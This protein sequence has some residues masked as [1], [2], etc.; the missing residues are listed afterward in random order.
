[1]ISKTLY[2]P[3]QVLLNDYFK[4][5]FMKIYM[6]EFTWTWLFAHQK[7]KVCYKAIDH[8]KYNKKKNH[9]INL[10]F[11]YYIFSVRCF[12]VHYY[13]KQIEGIVLSQFSLITS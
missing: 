5:F 12:S 7:L 6:I 3:G 2:I 9:K 1:M 13:S 8:M 10:D 11:I 4:T